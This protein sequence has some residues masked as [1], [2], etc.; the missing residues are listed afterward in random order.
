MTRIGPKKKKIIKS[1][2]FW[3][4]L[5]VGNDQRLKNGSIIQDT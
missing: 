3:R 4:T 2:D 1:T 5:Y